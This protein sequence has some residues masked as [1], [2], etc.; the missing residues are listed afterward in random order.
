M[1]SMT[2]NQDLHVK[3]TA[4]QAVPSFDVQRTTRSSV[5]GVLL[6]TI[7]LTVLLSAP[8][9]AERATLRVIVEFTCYLALAQM[10]N[11]LAGYAGLVSVGQQAFVG[12]RRISAV[13]PGHQV[14]A[15]PDGCRALC[16]H[17]GRGSWRF[18]LPS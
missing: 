15:T 2:N 16:R 9:W 12:P 18:Q 1:N 13:H 10:W 14:R 4:A 7:A 8:A 5:I 17:R 3:V 6:M 11:L